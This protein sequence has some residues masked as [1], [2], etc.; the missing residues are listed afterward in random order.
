VYV[1]SAADPGADVTLPGMGYGTVSGYRTLPPGTYTVSLR[2]AGAD[3]AT[4]PAL[5]TTVEVGAGAA[6]TVAVAGRFAG[7]GLRVLQD[8]LATPPPGEARMRVVA[9]AAQA[10]T[11][12]VSVAGGP[13]VA[14]AQPFASTGRYVDVPAGRTTLDVR[15]GG[16]AA[17]SLPVDVAPGA[18]YSVLVLDGSGG[19]LTVRPVLDA[20]GPPVVPSGSVAAGE[21]GTAGPTAGAV[22]AASAA[23]ISG[24]SA[25][26][27]LLSLRP[28]AARRAGR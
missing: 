24:L 2:G 4:P 7:L 1:D 13:T 21:G 16:S 26:G 12:D 23:G 27:L 15:P 25:V 18:V 20:A 5:S 28:R 9:A 11:L 8:D 3:P 10:G 22:V 6:R 14:R 17:T 19:G